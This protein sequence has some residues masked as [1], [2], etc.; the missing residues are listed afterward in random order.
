MRLNAFC[1]S[2]PRQAGFQ[3]QPHA[4]ASAIWMPWAPSTFVAVYIW[5][6][7]LKLLFC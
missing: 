1:L 7:L 2:P 4:T 3:L 5:S 6:K